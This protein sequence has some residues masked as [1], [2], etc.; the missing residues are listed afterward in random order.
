MGGRISYV[1]VGAYLFLILLL[2]FV[3]VPSPAV[4]ERYFVYLL[5]AITAF[6]L[7]RYLSTI[8]RLDDM[9]LRAGRVLGSRR[10][11]LSDV[12]KIE[13]TRLRD[14]APTGFFGSWG[15]RGRMWSPMIG[16]FDA[17]YTDPSGLLVTGGEVPLFI[18]PRRPEEFA[19]ELSRRARSYSGPLE[20]DHGAP[21]RSY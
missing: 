1:T 8:Y 9:Y 17:I 2:Y 18:S 19:R 11:R 21:T 3:V 6:L 13:F 5:I 15:W 14:L 10:V 20:V 16:K 12:R 7:L 4:G